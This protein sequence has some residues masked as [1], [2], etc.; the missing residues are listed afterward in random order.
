MAMGYI[1]TDIKF[2]RR[3]SVCSCASLSYLCCQSISLA[4]VF[5]GT[6]RTLILHGDFGAITN[7]THYVSQSLSPLFLSCCFINNYQVITINHYP[8]VTLYERYTLMTWSWSHTSAGRLKQ[9]LGWMVAKYGTN[10]SYV[11]V[12][13]VVYVNKNSQDLL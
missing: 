10:I 13:L 8:L 6:V 5:I 7:H 2:L 1:N 11:M 4:T 3:S 12:K 9:M